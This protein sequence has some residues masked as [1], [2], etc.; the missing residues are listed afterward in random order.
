MIGMDEDGEMAVLPKY[1]GKV[2]YLNEDYAYQAEKD[3]LVVVFMAKESDDLR[4]RYRK[5]M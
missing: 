4:H 3:L 2:Q 5:N 1:Q